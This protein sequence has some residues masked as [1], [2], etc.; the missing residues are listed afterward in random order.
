[1]VHSKDKLGLV[2]GFLKDISLVSIVQKLDAASI[3][4]GKG[5]KNPLTKFSNLIEKIDEAKGLKCTKYKIFTQDKKDKKVPDRKIL[6]VK[7][8]VEKREVLHYRTVYASPDELKIINGILQKSG[9]IKR[10][11]GQIAN[12]KEAIEE[13][14]KQGHGY[15]RVYNPVE[16]ERDGGKLFLQEI[17]FFGA[18]DK[19]VPYGTMYKTEEAREKML[20]VLRK[21]GLEEKPLQRKVGSKI[22]HEKIEAVL[23]IAGASMS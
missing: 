10:E 2:S 15:Y 1:M 23:G 21:S 11:V 7:F 18:G 14:S 9:F 5:Q 12:L 13:V 3:E 17:R 19:E 8:Y 20:E 16:C 22:K 6:H 4:A